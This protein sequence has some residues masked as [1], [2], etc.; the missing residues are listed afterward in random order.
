MHI[1]GPAPHMAEDAAPHFRDT[2]FF[3]GARG[4][5]GQP[6][7]MNG[8]VRGWTRSAMAQ[9]MLYARASLKHTAP[10]SDSQAPTRG[11]RSRAARL[12][13]SS[14]AVWSAVRSRVDA[15]RRVTVPPPVL[16][17]VDSPPLSS[18]RR[19][20]APA[21]ATTDVPIFLSEIPLLFRRGIKPVDVALVSV[22]PP[23]KHGFCRCGPPF[24]SAA[25][26]APPPAC[27]Q[28]R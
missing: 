5:R 4:G 18:P 25:G 26:V 9:D 16:C 21:T 19:S 11:P 2:S 10:E 22:S 12:T 23:D 28:P 8:W 14:R 6:L 17:R 1:D 27:G 15:R 24:L 13:V 7:D 20:A 3:T